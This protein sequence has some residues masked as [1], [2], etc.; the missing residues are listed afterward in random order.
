[1]HE[2]SGELE[3]EETDE[4]VRVRARLPVPVA[5]RYERFARDGHDGR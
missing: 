2:L 3:R 5:A 4:G 1:L